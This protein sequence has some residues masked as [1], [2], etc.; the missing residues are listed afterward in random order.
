MSLNYTLKISD[1]ERQEIVSAFGG[2]AGRWFK[3]INGHIYVV[4]ECGGATEQGS[5]NVCGAPIGGQNHVLEEYNYLATEMDGA[6][7][8]L[9]P[10]V[11]Q[12]N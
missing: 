9:Y 11:L 6:E 1:T 2:G 3:C 7:A 10:T 12:R 5:C 4:T 8:P